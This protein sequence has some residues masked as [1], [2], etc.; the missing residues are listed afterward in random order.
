MG[1]YRSGT[2]LLQGDGAEAPETTPMADSNH[3]LFIVKSNDG[4]RVRL[5][6]FYKLLED[7]ESFE[8]VIDGVPPEQ[9]NQPSLETGR[10]IWWSPYTRDCY[11]VTLDSD[12]K[13][14]QYD[15]VR[16]RVATRPN[17]DDDAKHV[18]FAVVTPSGYQVTTLND[19]RRSAVPQ[20]NEKLSLGMLQAW[21][22]EVFCER[23]LSPEELAELNR[24]TNAA[25]ERHGWP[26]LGKQYDAAGEQEQTRNIAYLM[27]KRE[28]PF[29]AAAFE[30]LEAL[31][32]GSRKLAS[33]TELDSASASL[34][35]GIEAYR[36]SAT[37]SHAENTDAVRSDA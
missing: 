15:I 14:Q 33:D 13:R 20:G 2:T 4:R 21:V 31:E 7:A 24:R 6:S 36:D 8:I 28:M 1:H 12:E 32:K 19:H 17:V 34:L 10:L 29:R 16:R 35:D 22:A 37:I 18:L 25:C 5:S 27:L 23:R 9:I 30:Y 26:D 11:T 3:K